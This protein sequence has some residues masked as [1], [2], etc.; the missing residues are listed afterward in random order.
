MCFLLYSIKNINKYLFI[1]DFLI[2]HIFT[3]G[4]RGMPLNQGHRVALA[5]ERGFNGA[6]MA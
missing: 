5:I 1:C 3:G 6:F 4:W 2:W